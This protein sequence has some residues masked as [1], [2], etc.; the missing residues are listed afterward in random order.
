MSSEVVWNVVKK[1]SA[2]MKKQKQGSKVTMF[3]TDKLNVTNYYTY[4]IGWES[5][6]I[7]LSTWVFARSVLLVW[8]AKASTL[9]WASSPPS[10]LW[11]L[12]RWCIR[13]MW[14]VLL[15]LPR[16]FGLCLTLI[17]RSRRDRIVLLW[18]LL[19]LL[20]TMSSI[21]L[22]CGWYMI[23]RLSVVLTKQFMSLLREQVVFLF[24]IETIIVCLVLF[25]T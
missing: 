24:V 25:A 7:D 13:L 9:C 15:L 16:R 19:L 11:S 20:V 8:I 3:S 1:N 6:R 23:F 4:W 14:S 10:T 17:S 2:F 12:A 18:G 22:F 5:D 21:R